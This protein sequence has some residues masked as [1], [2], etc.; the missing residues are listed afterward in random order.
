MRTTRCWACSARECRDALQCGAQLCTV[1]DG[2]ERGSLHCTTQHAWPPPTLLGWAGLG[3]TCPNAVGY[4]VEALLAGSPHNPVLVSER[5]N[6]ACTAGS[7]ACLPALLS[8]AWPS[9]PAQHAHPLVAE[10]S[11]LLLL[12]ARLPFPACSLP[13]MALDAMLMLPDYSPGTTT[14]VRGAQGGMRWP[15]GP[16]QGGGEGLLC[17]RGWP[18]DRRGKSQGE[19]QGAACGT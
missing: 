9:P 17:E 13:I 19:S 8:A 15:G 11:Y 16:L 3:R 6:G 4:K 1:R 12:S 2:T 18:A 14:K 10:L 7:S 5:A